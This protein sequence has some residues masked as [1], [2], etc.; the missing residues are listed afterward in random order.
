M[1]S[2]G[3]VFEEKPVYDWNHV[4]IGTV[5]GAVRDPKTRAARQLVLRLSPEAQTEL[6]TD[7]KTLE[8]PASL[9]FGVRRDSVTLDR[10]L[11]ELKK[12][13][14]FGSVLKR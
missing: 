11:S 2:E 10:S 3:F 4:P 13:D 5:S 9:V 14:F 7:E 12:I 1:Q 6:G 8:L